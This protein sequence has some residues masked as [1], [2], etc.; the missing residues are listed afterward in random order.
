MQKK[1]W[2]QG[3]PVH[4]PQDDSDMDQEENKRQAQYSQ[5]QEGRQGP[6]IDMNSCAGGSRLVKIHR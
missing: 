2:V 4:V 3:L 1:E 5:H 6:R